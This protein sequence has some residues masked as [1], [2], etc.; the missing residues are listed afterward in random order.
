MV[1]VGKLTLDKNPRNYFA[2][3]EQAGF[4]P[5]HMPPGIE[6]SPDKMLQVRISSSNNSLA[7]VSKTLVS[8]L[9]IYN[10]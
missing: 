4:S 9:T 6:P 8:A 3:V 5:S 1:E 2:D 10:G 7:P